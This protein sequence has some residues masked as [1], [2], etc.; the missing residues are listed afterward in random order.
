MRKSQLLVIL[1]ARPATMTSNLRALQVLLDELGWSLNLYSVL[2]IS[3]TPHVLPRFQ[4]APGTAAMALGRPSGSV[5]PILN[6]YSYI[7]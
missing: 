7:P 3:R 1:W 5:Y 6:I 4:P 2:D